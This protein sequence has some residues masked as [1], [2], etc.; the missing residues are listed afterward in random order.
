MWITRISIN[1]PVFSEPE[2]IAGM[3]AYVASAEAR[4]VNGAVLA[5]DGGIT[6]G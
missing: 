1:N 3:V 4:Y 2:E 5:I 6:A